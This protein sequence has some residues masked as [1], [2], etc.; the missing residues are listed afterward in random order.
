MPTLITDFRKALDIRRISAYNIFPVES[1]IK[2]VSDKTVQ[3]RDVFPDK[4]Q[5]GLIVLANIHITHTPA[6][7]CVC[8]LEI[9]HTV[10]VLD[11]ICFI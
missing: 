4:C 3:R 11:Q 10:S 8:R 1:I 9:R 2:S 6:L 7:N 5:I